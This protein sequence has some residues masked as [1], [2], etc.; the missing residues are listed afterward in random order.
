M[1]SL[2]VWCTLKDV[3]DYIARGN[4]DSRASDAVALRWAC[5]YY[6]LDVFNWL[7][8]RGLTVDDARAFDSA[9]LGV[10]RRPARDG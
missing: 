3:Q 6:R 10:L 4:G 7:I 5:T 2:P 1:D 9:A 8:G